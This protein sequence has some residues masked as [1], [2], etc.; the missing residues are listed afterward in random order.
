MTKFAGTYL[1]YR[2]EVR[3]LVIKQ[4]GYAGPKWF[5]TQAQRIIAAYDLG[6]PVE[7]LA[8]TLAQFGR[9]AKIGP[10]KTPRQLAKRV[11]RVGG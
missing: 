5:E 10:T 7:F 3:D 9:H 1:N 4:D 11:V 6:E 8:D 2:E